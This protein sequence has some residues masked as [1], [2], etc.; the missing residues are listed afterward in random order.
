MKQTLVEVL[1]SLF[2]DYMQET[3]DYQ[4][5]KQAEKSAHDA[6][7]ARVN[8]LEQACQEH[9][10]EI[11]NFPP[12]N[13]IVE[14]DV[15]SPLRIY[16]PQECH[17]LCIKCRGLLTFL[18]HLG[19]LNAFQREWIINQVTIGAARR[20]NYDEF[21]WFVFYTLFTGNE[22]TVDA[23]QYGSLIMNSSQQSH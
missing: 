20:P 14:I 17:Y 12:G 4:N 9:F 6:M 18:E 11:D 10:N 13:D 21:K 8:E 7:A 16:S 3:Q 2:H 15:K 23:E 22:L 1:L 5:N 19:A